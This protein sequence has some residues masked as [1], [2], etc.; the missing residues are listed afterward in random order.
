MEIVLGKFHAGFF[1]ALDKVVNELSHS[2]G[3]VVN[4]Q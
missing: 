2:R 3:E 4:R 1:F